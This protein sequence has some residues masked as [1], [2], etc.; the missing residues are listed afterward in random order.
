MF[1]A[2][3]ELLL[4]Y[5]RRPDLQSSFPEVKE[6]D[7]KGLLKWASYA[8]QNLYEDNEAFK[9][10]KQ[11]RDFYYFASNYENFFP[12]PNWKTLPKLFFIFGAGRSGTT[13]LKRIMNSHSLTSCLDEFFSYHGINQP[14]LL[15]LESI[16]ESKKKWLGLKCPVMT[17]C[18][19]DKN[20]IAFPIPNHI[21]KISQNF[22]NL[23]SNQPIIFLVRD[24]R[25]RVSSVIDQGKNTN[26]NMKELTKIFENWVEKNLYIQ[27]NF[28]KELSTIK[29]FKDKIF[30][31]EAL[32]WKIK[33]SAFSLYKERDYPILLIK[34][35]NLVSKTE[36][37]L[38]KI[39]SFLGIPFEKSMLNFYK[40][41]HVGLK[42][43]GLEGN[44]DNT[45]RNVDS[46]SIG[47]Y[48]KQLT[49]ENINEIMEI[50]S[51]TMRN[52]NY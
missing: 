30:G 7:L 26:V 15:K 10:L 52:L 32:E 20:F 44:L 9:F 6:G 25:D 49:S 41:P 38:R 42:E 34:Y 51:D 8:S 3:R 31:Y 33:T 29:N 12:D 48:K 5:C 35:E 18:L 40:M 14:L 46:N 50:A 13:L 37:S 27:E 22:R 2:L 28:K 24:V 21:D 45:R 11:K 16:F 36:E 19:L 4:Y 17:D 1:G 43:P 47:L 23:Y 39:C